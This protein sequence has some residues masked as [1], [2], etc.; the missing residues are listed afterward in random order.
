M[1]HT[2][3]RPRESTADLKV[4]MQSLKQ[5]L[6]A[7][8]L[9]YAKLARSLNVSEVTIK[10]WFSGSTCTLQNVFDVCA[11][12]DIS[13]FDL[14]H[15]ARQE[16][17]L[18]YILTL[19][20]EKVFAAEPALFGV[21]KLLQR[22]EVPEKIA[23]RWRLSPSSLFRVLRRLEKLGL[24]DLLAGEKVRLK[25]RGNIR[26]Q[27]QGPFARAIL[28]PQIDLFLDHVDRV[29]KNK[30]V[31]M[32]SAELELSENSISEM[33]GEIHAM[34]AKYRA[35]ALRDKS[36]VPKA[37]LKSVRWLLSFSPYE[38]DWSHYQLQ[39]K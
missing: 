34:G 24:I 29:L 16:E 26:C 31:C 11:V 28:R 37:Q 14:A 36:V 22:G 20:Q 19:E 33:V 38:T 15:L 7:K 12:L 3:K 27:H 5:V 4:L 23:L 30:D 18:D 25:F 35:R 32:H 1:K 8:S 17:E 6:R 39:T 13:F 10:R 9:T 2:R 21:L